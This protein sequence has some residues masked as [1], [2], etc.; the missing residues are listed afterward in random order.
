MSGKGLLLQLDADTLFV[1]FPRAQVNLKR[2]KAQDGGWTWVAG[3]STSC[4]V[5]CYGE[6]ITSLF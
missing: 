2:S 1:Q 4:L 6:S 5:T 3:H